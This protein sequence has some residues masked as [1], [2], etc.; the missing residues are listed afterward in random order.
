MDRSHRQ[1]VDERV[2]ALAVVE[3]LDDA[4]AARSDGCFESGELVGVGSGTL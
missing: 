3:E 2:A 1:V 4:G